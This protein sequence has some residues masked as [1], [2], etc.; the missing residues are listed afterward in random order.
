M[1][2]G[3]IYKIQFPNGK[4]YIGLTTTSIKQR[5]RGH[6]TC[7]KS[8]D[9]KCLYN[10]IR[11]YDMVESF[12][13]IEIDTADTIEE[14]CELEIGYIIEYNSY[15]MNGRGYN[16]THGGEG[17]NGYVFTE[18]DN[19][20]NSERRLQ[21][22]RDHPEAGKE[23]SERMIQYYVDNPEARQQIGEI[24][25]Q[26]HIDHPEAGKE[27]SERMIQYYV[28]NP[29]A[30]RKASEK[31]KIQ[32]KSQEARQKQ[33]EILK[34]FNKDHPEAGKEQSIRLKQRHKDHPEIGEKQSERLKQL[35]ICNEEAREK[36]VAP[37][38]QF[39]I[40]NPDAR[41]EQGERRR[42]YNKDNPEVGIQ[43][44]EKLKKHYDNNPGARQKASETQKARSP[45]WKKKKS[46]V[47]GLNKQFDVF[48][49]DGTFVKTFTYQFEAMEYLQEEYHITSRVKIGEVLSGKR[50]NSAGF[51][52][53][54]K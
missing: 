45:E 7:A 18:D 5:T 11:K 33:S 44:G 19:I 13:L 15:Y 17:T 21:F 42:Q 47:Q 28:D 27:H 49:M 9:N 39:H 22:H 41:K 14:L 29:D 20:K 31:S 53:K 48:T 43:Q 26:F 46:D 2:C 51:V 35:Y 1:S 10:A 4:H 50:N 54:Y 12:E 25:K 38:K 6:R 32:F 36:C 40:D 16:M 37:L 24:M 34:Q 3:S 8:G 30:R 23:H 52:F